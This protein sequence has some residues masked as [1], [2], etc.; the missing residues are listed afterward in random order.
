MS[1]K[2]Y[3]Y[4]YVNSEYR[5][6]KDLQ[7]E[8][9]L[10]LNVKYE[11]RENIRTGSEG[12]EISF[13]NL[14]DS[15][16][17]KGQVS[18]VHDFL[19]SR[20]GEEFSVEHVGRGEFKRD[21]VRSDDLRITTQSGSKYIL[22]IKSSKEP[23]QYFGKA[24]E[25]GLEQIKETMKSNNDIK[26]AWLWLNDM[27]EGKSYIFEINREAL[28][29]FDVQEIRV[30]IKERLELRG[31]IKELHDVGRD[32]EEKI[33]IPPEFGKESGAELGG[34][35]ELEKKIIKELEKFEEGGFLG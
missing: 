14:L 28:E 2:A 16:K 35:R 9:Q 23:E 11:A 30:Q 8:P 13:V 12:E 31:E 15:S 33:K 19:V 27:K 4:A 21:G 17:L 5:L 32:V 10:T 7:F 25:K 20:I 24:I 6:L 26:G 18:E 3:Y 22:E 1:W 29:N 34:L